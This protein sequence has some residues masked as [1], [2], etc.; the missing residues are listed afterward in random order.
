VLQAGVKDN[1][2]PTEAYALVNYRL[3]PG[4][5]I[6]DIEGH[7]R[8]TIDDAAI[9]LSVEDGFGNEAPP[10]SD[11]DA[12]EFALIER[13]VNE[14]FPEAVVSSGLIAAT[15]DNRHY[16]GIRDQGYYFAPFVY[17]ADDTARIHGTD[18]RIAIAA[19]ADM[20][21]FYLRLLRNAGG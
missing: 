20:V 6:A 1:I 10:L 21:R 4:T 8:T 11:A 16:A 19:Y 5:R 7:I 2:I 15:T 18:E 9:T 12:P 17:T 13:S 3:L 14:V